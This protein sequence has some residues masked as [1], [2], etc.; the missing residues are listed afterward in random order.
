MAAA[1]PMQT[2]PISNALIFV[3]LFMIQTSK[4]LE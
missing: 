4:L 3:M 2:T 1:D